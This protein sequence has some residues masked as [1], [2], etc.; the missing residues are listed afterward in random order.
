MSIIKR[1]IPFTISCAVIFHKTTIFPVFEKSGK[2]LKKSLE[3][4]GLVLYNLVRC[5]IC[6]F[7]G[8]KREVTGS[9]RIVPADNRPD[10]DPD[11]PKE[12]R[13]AKGTRALSKKSE[14]THTAMCVSEHGSGRESEG[15]VNKWQAKEL[16][17][18]SKLTT[19]T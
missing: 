11:A 16:E 14:T 7:F 12:D 9:H 3:I 8:M 6:V 10:V 4:A 13:N 17:S 2:N 5:A 1:K 15:G 18:S 19:T